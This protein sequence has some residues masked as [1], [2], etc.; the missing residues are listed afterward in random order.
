MPRV[1]DLSAP[2]PDDPSARP[3]ARLVA[4]GVIVRRCLRV[5]GGAAG[6]GRSVAIMGG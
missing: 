1:V 6:S 4:D 2:I 5:V 3:G